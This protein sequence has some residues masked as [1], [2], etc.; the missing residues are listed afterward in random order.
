MVWFFGRRKTSKATAD[1]QLTP[2]FIARDLASMVARAGDSPEVA[3]TL[4]K[5]GEEYSPAHR[6]EWL[7]IN[8]LAATQGFVISNL[9]ERF[10]QTFV[11]A[12]VNAVAS[13]AFHEPEAREKFTSHFYE[14]VQE[15]GPAHAA[16]S[17]NPNALA[18]IFGRR[19]AS[20]PDLAVSFFARSVFH[21][22]LMAANQIANNIA[23]I[24]GQRA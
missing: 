2:D 5:V 1:Q 23:S 4:A 22:K 11:P 19:L 18:L 15:Y 6:M 9:S 16:S 7:I 21:K 24:V 12:F 14:R 13:Q 8:T 17:E 20:T 3:E 10:K